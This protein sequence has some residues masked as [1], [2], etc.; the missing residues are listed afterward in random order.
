MTVPQALAALP[1]FTALR[2]TARLTRCIFYKSKARP[3]TSREITTHFTVV[4]CSRNRKI[5]E[6]GQCANIIL[7]NTGVHLSAFINQRGFYTMVCGRSPCLLPALPNRDVLAK[8]SLVSGSS[9]AKLDH[10]S[11]TFKGL[12]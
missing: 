12:L 5:S 4:V 1:G 9:S 2:F 8:L 10:N 11:T 3:S 7:G 6:V